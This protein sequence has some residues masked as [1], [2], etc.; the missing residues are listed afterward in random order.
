MGMSERRDGM[1]SEFRIYSWVVD[2]ITMWSGIF[3]GPGGARAGAGQG[4][5]EVPKMPTRGRVL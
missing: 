4:I 5:W 2:N 3:V 1:R